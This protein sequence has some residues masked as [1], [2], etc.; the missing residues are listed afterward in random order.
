MD[1]ENEEL[2]KVFGVEGYGASGAQ[3]FHAIM[4]QSPDHIYIKDMQS[5]FIAVSRKMANHFGLDSMDDAVGKTDADFFSEEHATQALMDEQE[6][7]RTGKPMLGKEEKETWEDGHVTWVSTTKAPIC[8]NSGKIVGLIGISRNVTAEHEARE[9]VARSEQ[10]LRVWE[11]RISRDLRS[12]SHVQKVFIPG[13]IPDFPGVDVALKLEPMDEVGGD[14]ITF[15]ES[16]PHGLLFFLGDV[17]GHGVTAALFTLLVKYLTDQRGGEFNGNLKHF[18]ECLNEG[19]VGRIPDGFVAGLCGQITKSEKRDGSFVFT[20]SNAGHREFIHY[21]ADSCS[22]ELVHLPLGNV[23][24]LPLD[25]GSE[26]ASYSIKPGDRLLFFTDGIVEMQNEN[27]E[28]F[29]YLRVAKTLEGLANLPGKQAIDSIVAQS[30]AFS[31]N[32]KATDD[33]SLLL[34]SF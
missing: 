4:E 15:P 31:G 17:T 25:A 34:L 5:R 10:K 33:V 26:D 19:L 22:A 32:R 6:I 30:R 1:K 7:L 28:E 23:L 16:P 2:G 8:L 13:D 3:L 29:G 27:G 9:A 14:I 21:H 11:E 24:G 18:L 20:A 12:A